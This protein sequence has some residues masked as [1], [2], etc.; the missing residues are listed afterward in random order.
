MEAP[1]DVADYTGSPPS[2]SV[3]RIR[4]TQNVADYSSLV[5]AVGHEA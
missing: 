3:P 5:V 2:I 1:G 4:A